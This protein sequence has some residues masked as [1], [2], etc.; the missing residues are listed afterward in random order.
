M[1]ELLRRNVD[2][3]LDKN[4]AHASLIY[5]EQQRNLLAKAYKDYIAVGKASKLSIILFT[6]TWKANRQNIEKS[7]FKTRNV[8]A[9]NASFL[10]DL[11][12]AE[13][14]YSDEIFLGGLIGCKGDSYKPNEAL[15]NGEA[16][17]F[18]YWQV[19]EL[20][21]ANVDFLFASTLPSTE[22][23][24]GIAKA[25]ARTERPYIL[26]FVVDGVGRVLD[27]VP[28]VKAIQ[29]ID[30]ETSRKPFGYF[31]NCVHPRA[32]ISGLRSLR[33]S[34]SINRIIGFQGNTSARNPEELSQLK[35]L[36]TQDP[37]IFANEMREL[38]NLFALKILGG[39]CGTNPAHI[40]SI[41]K[42]CR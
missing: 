30:E 33:T 12:S 10:I 13:E 36:E 1:F 40:A 16:E 9:E 35:E 14:N 38:K 4:L 6:A 17:E 20:A 32:F 21:R 29:R 8:N 42:A 3:R 39:C 18:H 34:H 5:D 28:L 41:A 19:S 25:M 2:I 37:Y 26:S 15:T 22:E 27:G 7:F 23:G 11:R 31:V 24:L